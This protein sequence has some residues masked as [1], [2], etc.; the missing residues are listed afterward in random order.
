MKTHH[1]DGHIGLK[2]E[3]H[4]GKYFSPSCCLRVR[5]LCNASRKFQDRQTRFHGKSRTII[6][7]VVVVAGFSE[8][9]W[10]YQP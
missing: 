5:E 2:C 4:K 10:D 8:S 6:I 1:Q 9:P 3:Q 7:V